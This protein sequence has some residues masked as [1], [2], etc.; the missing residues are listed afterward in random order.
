[1]VTRDVL[2]EIC[3][4]ENISKFIGCG[5]FVQH[6][7]HVLMRSALYAAELDPLLKPVLE[8]TWAAKFRG[9]TE[10]NT[11]TFFNTFVQCANLASIYVGSGEELAYASL[12][13]KFLSEYR[14]RRLNENL[15]KITD[16][17]QMGKIKFLCVNDNALT[18]GTSLPDELGISAASIIQ[19]WRLSLFPH[20]S[21]FELWYLHVMVK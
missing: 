17:I 1:M 8:Q 5:N 11:P 20:R 14:R 12:E 6:S 16:D 10:L 13:R 19:K 21:S 15:A 4:S 3:E 2:R 7:P 9:G 18:T